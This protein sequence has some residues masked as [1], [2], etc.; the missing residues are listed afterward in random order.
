MKKFV[1]LL[2]EEKGKIAMKEWENDECDILQAVYSVYKKLR[3]I[4]F[5]ILT[6]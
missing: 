3:T 1:A 6:C 5:P 2:T 4:L